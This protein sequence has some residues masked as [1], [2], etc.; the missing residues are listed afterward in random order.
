MNLRR[1]HAVAR[2]EFLHILRDSRPGVEELTAQGDRE[3][4]LDRNPLHQRKVEVGLPR[5]LDDADA[6]AVATDS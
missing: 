1:T 4:L 5:P 6:A 3:S 2:K